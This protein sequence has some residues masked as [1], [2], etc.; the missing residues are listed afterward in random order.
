MPYS[1]H[2]VGAGKSVTWEYEL[3]NIQGDCSGRDTC[4]AVMKLGGDKVTVNFHY[5]FRHC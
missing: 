1:I 5:C 3:G 4:N 2:A